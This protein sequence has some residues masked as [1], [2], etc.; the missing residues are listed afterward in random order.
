VGKEHT[1]DGG[2]RA[3]VFQDEYGHRLGRRVE[4]GEAVGK[5]AGASI[6]GDPAGGAGGGE[7]RC[8]AVDLGV[9]RAVS[10]F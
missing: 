9:E 2:G 3:L 1:A 6:D 10:G 8:G 4:S 7:Q 5:A